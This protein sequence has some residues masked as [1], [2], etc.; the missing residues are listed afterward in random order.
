MNDHQ[1]LV[2][3]GGP[4]LGLKHRHN[5]RLHSTSGQRRHT[6][7]IPVPSTSK[8]VSPNVITQPGHERQRRVPVTRT[9]PYVRVLP[10]FWRILL[11]HP[12]D[13]EAVIE[14][15][16]VKRG[17]TAH[18]CASVRERAWERVAAV[19]PTCTDSFKVPN[20]GDRM[21][22]GTRTKESRRRLQ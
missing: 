6:P 3:L 15:G 18:Y 7:P 2:P 8:V 4:T 10:E 12:A 22:A 14:L 13:V 19:V 5:M 17:M 16:D 11:H 21:S 9:H 20:S 1:R